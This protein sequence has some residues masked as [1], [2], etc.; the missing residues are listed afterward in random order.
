MLT[1]SLTP[2]TSLSLDASFSLGLGVL[3][4]QFPDASYYGIS[5]RRSLAQGAWLEAVDGD[6]SVGD[7]VYGAFADEVGVGAVTWSPKSGRN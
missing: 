1:T 2:N 6:S 4:A 7:D 3:C 5:G